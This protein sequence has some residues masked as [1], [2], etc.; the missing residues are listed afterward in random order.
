MAHAV[1][2]P[3]LRT[4][5]RKISRLW[6]ASMRRNNRGTTMRAPIIV[7][8]MATTAVSSAT[9]LTFFLRPG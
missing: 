5:S 1:P 8:E 3:T 9:P 2:S 7:A 4:A 6:A